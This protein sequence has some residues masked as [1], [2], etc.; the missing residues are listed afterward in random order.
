MALHKQYKS[1][2]INEVP[3]SHEKENIKI[4]WLT[5]TFLKASAER[6]SKTAPHRSISDPSSKMF[7][8]AS[9]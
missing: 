9:T 3:Y 8:S 5:V 7:D 4:N 1:G 2:Y 6:H